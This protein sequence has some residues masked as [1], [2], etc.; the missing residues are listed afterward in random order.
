M[1][2]DYNTFILQ[3][4]IYLRLF[5][6]VH[7]NILHDFTTEARKECDELQRMFTEMNAMFEITA[8]FYGFDPIKHP[9]QT[10]MGYINTFIHQWDVS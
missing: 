9:I 8:K 7:L 1:I 4:N 3:T 5:S 2:L 6:F 10:T